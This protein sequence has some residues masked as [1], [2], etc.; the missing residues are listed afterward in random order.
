VIRE[1]VTVPEV[2]L[3]LFL[4]LINLLYGLDHDARSLVTVK[5]S[6]TATPGI[7]RPGDVEARDADVLRLASGSLDSI[8]ICQ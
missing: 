5:L 1:R 3:F 8:H 7:S 2:C 4:T 6:D